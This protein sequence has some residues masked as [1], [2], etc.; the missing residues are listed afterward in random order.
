MDDERV[1]QPPP[2]L[3]RVFILRL[4]FV[5]GWRVFLSLRRQLAPNHAQTDGRVSN[6]NRDEMVG[7]GG[8]K[9]S[10]PRLMSLP[11]ASSPPH[12][13]VLTDGT[14]RHE[15]TGDSDTEV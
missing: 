11:W 6:S 7:G 10:I 15:P 13:M 2:P 12:C 4:S 8:G 1:I 5:I 3:T 9:A 14:S